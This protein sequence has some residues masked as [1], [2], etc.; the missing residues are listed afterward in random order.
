MVRIENFEMLWKWSFWEVWRTLRRF[1]GEQMIE[2]IQVWC[3]TVAG[4]V[5]SSRQSRFLWTIRVS[6]TMVGVE[7]VLGY[8]CCCYRSEYDHIRSAILQCLLVARAG[9]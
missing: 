3:S 2:E 6:R 4:L 7:E 9:C 1:D 8:A 5:L